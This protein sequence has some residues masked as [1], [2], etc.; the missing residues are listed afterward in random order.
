VNTMAN[1]S[2]RYAAW[3]LA[4]IAAVNWGTVEAFQTNLLTDTLGLGPEIVGPAYLVIGVAGVVNLWDL[5]MTV[6]EA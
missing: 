1:E 5:G 2:I 4:A 6:S 3:L